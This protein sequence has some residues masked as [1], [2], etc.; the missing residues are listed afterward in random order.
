MRV[1]YRF[2]IGDGIFWAKPDGSSAPGPQ[3]LID[4]DNGSTPHSHEGALELFQRE[5]PEIYERMGNEQYK[6]VWDPM[7]LD[8]LRD[9]RRAWGNPLCCTLPDAP[10]LKIVITFG[11]TLE[12][13]EGYQFKGRT[14]SAPVSAPHSLFHSVRRPLGN[15][16]LKLTGMC[17]LR[18]C[19]ALSG[20]A[21]VPRLPG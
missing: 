21:H 7:C 12:A 10:D 11:G 17:C 4:V 3:R 16:T 6:G 14:S 5:T 8:R 20:S 1:S 15:W 19:V 13:E 9:D 2:P 18:L